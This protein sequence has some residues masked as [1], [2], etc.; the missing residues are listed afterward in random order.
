MARQ[1]LARV[2]PLVRF[3]AVG[4][5]GLV[6]DIAVLWAA[7]AVFGLNP[8]AGRFPSF[9]AAVTFTWAANRHLTFGTARAREWK[10]MPAEW[11]RFTA[12]SLFG[13][14]VNYAVYAA[15]ISLTPPPFSNPF[16]AAFIGS[17][18]GMMVNYT[19]AKRLAFRAT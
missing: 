18:A 2:P 14:A 5:G 9:L 15:L 6:V 13:F 10:H 8:Y 17:L 11:L 12:V 16:L 19:G 7:I 4:T 1:V 3:A